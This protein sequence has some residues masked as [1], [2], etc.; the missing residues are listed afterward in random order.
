MAFFLAPLLSA[1]G[2]FFATKVGTAVATTAVS[3]AI[4]AVN[5]KNQNK[6]ANAAY[7]KM[8]AEQAE[9][10]KRI[11]AQNEANKIE[12]QKIDDKNRITAQQDAANK[13][14]DMNAAAQKAGL[15]PL[16]VLRATG[17]SGFGA[18]GGYG[19][20][21]QDGIVQPTVQAPILSNQSV[22]QQIGLGALQG[23]IDF[24]ANERMNEHYDRLNELDL[25]QRKIDIKLGNAQLDQLATSDPYRKFGDTIPVRVGNNTQQ[26]DVTVARRMG[27]LPND[28]IT[29]GDLEEIR[30]EVHGGIQTAIESDIGGVILPRTP[31]GNT[32]VGTPWMDNFVGKIT[33]IINKMPNTPIVPPLSDTR[34]NDEWRKYVN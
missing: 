18:Y 12:Q 6:A 7:N 29:A 11:Q 22:A 26:L 34:W 1:A 23:F 27:I 9:E 19:A 17:G 15:N 16:T 5:Q 30:G 8:L 10:R 31:G 28:R 14:V 21:L 13:F 4:G 32:V 20:V 33:N 24:K 25:E 3:A 2:S